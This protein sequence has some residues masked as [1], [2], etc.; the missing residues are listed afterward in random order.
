MIAPNI[1]PA[2]QTLCIDMD[3]QSMGSVATLLSC[4]TAQPLE[5]SR[6]RSG[7][8]LVRPT[9]LSLSQE[10]E[11]K[12]ADC[13]IK[14]FGDLPDDWDGFKAAAISPEAVNHALSAITILRGHAKP[15][16][17]VPDI[18]PETNGT[19][20]MQWESSGGHAHLEIGRTRYAGF[21]RTPGSQTAYFDGPAEDLGAT[22]AANPLYSI[23][24]RLF[25]GP[26][27]VS[28]FSVPYLAKRANG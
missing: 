3:Q 21:L 22:S 23:I 15:I 16:D 5:A 20:S 27:V 2:S 14:K 9:N 17:V 8:R 1:I 12:L 7:D 6:S 19:I 18:S 4:D 28:M 25:A 26:S 11:F 10:N 24:G 13:I